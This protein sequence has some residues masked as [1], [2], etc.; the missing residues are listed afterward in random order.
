MEIKENED[1]LLNEKKDQRILAYVPDKTKQRSNV[2]RRGRSDNDDVNI[3][4]LIFSLASG[5]SKDRLGQYGE[6]REQEKFDSS[7]LLTSTATLLDKTGKDDVGQLSRLIEISVTKEDMIDGNDVFL[8]GFGSFILKKRAEKTARNISKNV[9]IIIPEHN[10]P[11][12]KP[13]KTF[14]NAVAGR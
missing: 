5:M 3:N 4:E 1:I 9:T 14:L 2:D 11:A 13:A 12:F 8:R 7:V 6:L 10:I